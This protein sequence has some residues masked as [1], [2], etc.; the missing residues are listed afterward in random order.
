LPDLY[1]SLVVICRKAFLHI[2]R[3]LVQYN[4]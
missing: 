1:K 4:G 3:K 2:C